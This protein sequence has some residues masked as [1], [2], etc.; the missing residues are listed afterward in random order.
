MGAGGEDIL[1]SQEVGDQLNISIECKSRESIAVYAF[2]SQAADNCP[3]GREPVVIIKQNH[4]KPLA[5]IDAEYYV[6][7]LKGTNET[8]DNS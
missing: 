7:L 6:K 4:S 2:Y 5:V 8:F 3:E 1:F